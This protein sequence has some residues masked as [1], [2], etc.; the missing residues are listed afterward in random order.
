MSLFNQMFSPMESY[1]IFTVFNFLPH[2]IFFLLVAALVAVFFLKVQKSTI[3]RV[4]THSKPLYNSNRQNDILGVLKSGKVSSDIKEKQLL[5][6]KSYRDL[7]EDHINEDI[8]LELDNFNR[9]LDKKLLDNLIY[10]F[11][12]SKYLDQNLDNPNLATKLNSLSDEFET[13]YLNKE[14]GDDIQHIELLGNLVHKYNADLEKG[15][16]DA[17]YGVDNEFLEYVEEYDLYL[18]DHPQQIFQLENDEDNSAGDSSNIYDEDLIN[19][20]SVDLNEMSWDANSDVKFQQEWDDILRGDDSLLSDHSLNGYKEINS[21]Y[22]NHSVNLRDDDNFGEV[23]DFLIDV[24]FTE[25]EKVEMVET[26]GHRLRNIPHF[27]DEVLMTAAL[28]YLKTGKSDPMGRLGNIYT[29]D[30]KQLR[31]Q[32][33]SITTVNADNQL[34]FFKILRSNNI[35]RKLQRNLYDKVYKD[36]LRIKSL[37]LRILEQENENRSLR[38]KS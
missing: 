5:E 10:T 34:L 15:D 7:K 16:F 13:V 2:T 24:C 1:I 31:E 19:G 8:L 36:R 29:V 14:P 28:T 37:K 21:E 22:L 27:N 11:M 38:N 26:V 17:D 30:I 32:L 25:E 3:V 4:R 35:Y 6:L 23:Y 33:V 18:H 12:Y 20:L 9:D